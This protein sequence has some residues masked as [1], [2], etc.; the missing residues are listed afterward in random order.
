MPTTLINIKNKNNK[1]KSFI[2]IG[3]GTV[4]GNANSHLEGGLSRKQAC[5]S[6]RY[7][8]YKK[9][10][11]NYKFK[12]QVLFL[13]NKTIGCSCLPMMCHG[14]IIKEYLDSIIDIDKEVEAVVKRLMLLYP[15]LNVN[16]LLP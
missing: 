13:H 10:K 8:F 1:S 11:Y 14:S 4:F 9:I 3:R 6:Y 2:Y 5:E 16:S 12:F 15:N 7:D